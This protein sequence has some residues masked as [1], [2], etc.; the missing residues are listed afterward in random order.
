MKHVY[1]ASLA[2]VLLMGHGITA[3]AADAPKAGAKATTEAPKAA[4]SAP[5]KSGPGPTPARLPDGKPNWTGFWVPLNGLL[6]V[7][8]GPSGL[9]GAA[10]GVNAGPTHDPTMPPMKSPYK[11]QYDAAFE[12][13][14]KGPLPN[15]VALCYPVGMP[16]MMGMI[17][18]MEILQTPNIYAITSEWQAESRRVWMDL[19][20]HPPLE[21]LD[22]TYDGH[23]IGHWEGDVLVIDTVGL[24]PDVPFRAQLPYQHSEKTRIIE[25]FS[26]PSPDILVNEMTIIDPDVFE[27][28]WPRKFTYRYRPDWRLREYVCLENNRN[29]DEEGRQKF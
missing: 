25:R 1:L 28:P 26:Q 19:K 15:K 16:G 11:E 24:R 21:E 7:Y 22:A 8:R 4:T 5:T 17:Y 6:D 14:K 27:K 2:T 12:A 13:A 23:S 20:E 9:D 29:V 18:G 10:R 3:V